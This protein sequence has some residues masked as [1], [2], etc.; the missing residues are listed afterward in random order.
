M[1]VVSDL[2]DSRGLL[3]NLTLREVRGKYKRTLLGQ[4]WSLLNPIATLLIYTLVFGFVLRVPVPVGEDSGLQVFVLFLACALL[5]WNFFNNAV[6]SG[7][8]SLIAN[9]NLL[10]K[11]FFWRP[12]LVVAT[13]LSLN[14]TFAIELGVLVVLLLLFGSMPLPWIP[15]LLLVVVLL[16]A[17]ALGI[18]LLLS[19][20]NVYFRDTQ[21]FVTIGMQLWFYATPIVYPYQLIQ[22][23]AARMRAAGN[24][25]PLETIYRLNPLERFVSVFRAML[26]DNVMPYWG[27]LLFCLVAA[28]GSLVIGFAVFNRSQHR[29]VEEL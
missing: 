24:D 27:D 25:F 11:V 26:Y 12:T 1:S 4:G 8:G 16:T 23:Q 2:K 7:M 29:L 10:R 21:H 9:A 22:D 18:A 13:V 6:S 20:A 19:V 15:L 5:P 17:F 3:V 14:V 28:V